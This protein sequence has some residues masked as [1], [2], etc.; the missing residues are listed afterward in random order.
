MDWTQSALG[1]LLV[2]GLVGL[3]IGL[4][5]E[6][7]EARKARAQFAGVRTF[8]LIALAGAAPALLLPEM[9][10]W[11]LIISFVAVAAIT[12]V[13]YVRSSSSAVGAT[14]E[15]AALAT[16]LL[17][18]LAGAGHLVVAAAAGVAVAVLLVAKPRLEGFSQRLSSAELSAALE[19]AVVS[20]IVLPLLP[21][22]GYGPWE[23]LNPFDIWLVVVLVSGLSFAGFVATRWFGDGRG[24]L[25]AGAIGGLVS[26]TA[27]T[28]AMANESRASPQNAALRAAAA[29]LAS[30]IMCLR[31]AAF[32]AMFNPQ[33]L[34]DLLPI[35]GA[36]T[37]TG[38]AA[39]FWLRRQ[40]ASSRD[41]EHAP[42]V[43]NPTHLAAAVVFA[44]IYAGVL[45]LV[46]ATH[47]SVG[48]AGL[49]VAAMLSS[50]ADVDAAAIAFVQ[51]GPIDGSWT[52]AV[53]AI[54]I[55]M[56]TNT[57]VKLVIAITMGA[58]N[59][60]AYVA[61]ALGVMTAM[62]SAVLLLVLLVKS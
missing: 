11:L 62:G 49:Y 41:P 32:A 21:N 24:I 10:P 7:A 4:D 56:I 51:M 37:G 34:A 44:A 26:S 14:T 46:R 54:T 19:L 60:R 45:L 17:G 16:F 31:V 53:T 2:A 57:L 27:V 29:V 18:V 42:P 1:R 35:V 40:V 52:T 59:F 58:G 55:A 5:R 25:M 30:A 12:L 23:V 36:M 22:R 33:I 47:E 28:V 6:R 8:P 13:A 9:G 39:A 50:V 48:A 3:L 38:G 43:G 61:A 20:V 15:M